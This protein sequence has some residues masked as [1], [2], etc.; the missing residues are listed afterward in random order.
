MT[1]V[2]CLT[3]GFQDC[4]LFLNSDGEAECN[5]CGCVF[6]LDEEEMENLKG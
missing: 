6:D 1:C 3:R 4:W 5:S 2:R